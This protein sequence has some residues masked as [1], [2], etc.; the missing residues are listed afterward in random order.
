MS[1]EVGGEADRV[2]LASGA[3]E[4]EVNGSVDADGSTVNAVNV[5]DVMRLID[6]AGGEAAADGIKA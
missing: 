6:I 2:M 3:S 4:S 1:G 5:I